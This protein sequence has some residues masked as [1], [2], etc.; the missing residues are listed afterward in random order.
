[1]PE[2]VNVAAM[3]WRADP[4]PGRWILPLVVLGMMAFTYLFIRELPG[5]GATSTT[6]GSDATVPTTSTTGTVGGATSTTSSVELSPEVQ[7]YLDAI[8]GFEDRLAELRT[9]LAAAN[10]GFDANPR[11]VDY[12]DAVTRF[13]AVATAMD[14]LVTDIS[15]L[16][17]PAEL[18]SAH[19]PLITEATNA[20]VAADGAV[21][22]LQLPPP[23]TGD[24]RRQQVAAFDQAVEAFNQAA[25]NLRTLAGV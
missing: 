6:T 23:D 25:S 7:A 19:E 14:Q 17:P 2:P 4:K 16:T 5:A 20:S 1:M 12:D 21:E 8:Q 10:S 18:A 11:T 24:T 22:G 13:E 9:E 3:T 15:A